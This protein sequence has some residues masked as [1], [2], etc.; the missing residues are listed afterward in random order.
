MSLFGVDLGCQNSSVSVARRRGVDICL[1][2]VSKRET[3]TVVS[4]GDGDRERLIGESGAA[5]LTRQIRNT[6]PNLKRLIGVRYDSTLHKHEKKYC[7]FETRASRDGFI[8]VAANVRGEQRWYA[9]EQ[10]V[11]M[12]LGKMRNDAETEANVGRVVD[13]VVAVPCYW[14]A[15]QRR[16]LA[17]AAAVAEYHLLNIMNET[18]A[19][20]LCYGVARASSLPADEAS[21]ERLL[22]VDM[23]H[24]TT[25]LSVVA[26]WRD[27][28]KVQ[29]HMC[30]PYTGVRDMIE[31][32]YQH[33]VEEV[34]KKYH[35]DITENPKNAV[36]LWSSVE[37]AFR[38][39][40]AN[41]VTNLN[42]ELPELDISFPSVKREDW[43]N[44]YKGQLERVQRL[45]SEAVAVAG[46]LGSVE[47]IGGGSRIPA[48]R[49]AIRQITQMEPQTTQNAT[50]VVAK[51]VGLN[52]AMLSPK[53]SLGGREFSV[54]D[55]SPHE[56]SVMYASDS[57]SNHSLPELPHMN[58]RVALLA[59]NA[60]LPKALTLTFERKQT[61][62]LAVVYDDSDIVTQVGGSR[63]L[64]VWRVEVPPQV[65]ETK[66]APVRVAVRLGTAGIVAVDSAHIEEEYQEEAEVEVD[67]EEA[68][69]VSSAKM[70]VDD[71]TAE[72][73]KEEEKKEEKKDDKAMA[74]DDAQAKKGK[75]K[76]TQ[77]VTKTR[78]LNCQVVQ[79]QTLE[80]TTATLQE[81]KE[82]ERSLA[83]HDAKIRRTAEAKNELEAFC[84]NLKAR[85]GSSG[86]LHAYAP[87]K[88]AEAVLQEG[89]DVL[90]WLDGDGD[91]VEES[92]YRKRLTAMQKSVEPFEARRR[93][94]AALADAEQEAL[95]KLQ[96]TRAKVNEARYKHLDDSDRQGIA[97][98]CE[99]LASWVADNVTNAKRPTLQDP[100]VTASNVR[101]KIKELDTAVNPIF[102]KPA[103]APA[104]AAADGAKAEAKAE[105]SK[106]TSPTTEEAPAA[107]PQ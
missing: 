2:E 4:F 5:Q 96:T 36:R 79:T 76:R 86:E 21:A 75:V 7:R 49:S 55:A 67:A 28:M 101:T 57:R 19:A 3:P 26:F 97:T 54:W 66:K 81:W 82:M 87:T 40:S 71:D 33:Y 11:A 20:A 61:F 68:E 60:T 53:F 59:L 45:L 73:K 104:P 90:S 100:P 38:V 23:G 6:F 25:T 89:E 102:G 58:K 34:K 47:V 56:I 106:P 18:T 39:L 92:E 93:A 27:A 84:F 13:S 64:G 105:S 70:E 65:T 22:L 63:V 10:L 32:V 29:F 17:A 41:P 52:G 14:T 107:D 43:E 16:R 48:V 9:V 78:R 31:A 72:V 24:S 44:L 69:A 30:D 94:F 42:C 46:D 80:M 103:P 88:D 74:T 62:D 37:K 15:G 83:N 95:R 77:Q 1:N 35:I 50:E 91:D 99:S 8:E 51:G 98:A 12:F 85:L